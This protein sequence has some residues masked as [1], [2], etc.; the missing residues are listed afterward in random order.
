MKKKERVAN[1]VVQA[2]KLLKDATRILKY[3]GGRLAPAA[4]DECGGW[5]KALA[6]ALDGTRPDTTDRERLESI[7][8]ASERLSAAMKASEKLL[9][10]ATIREYVES[11]GTAVVLALLVR[12]FVFEAFHIPT[13]SMIPTVNIA[14]H[15]FVNKYIYGLR[16]PFTHKDIVGGRMPSRGEVVVFDFPVPGENYGQ[17]FLKRV[18]GLPGDRVRL[19]GNVLEINGRPIEVKPIVHDGDC[20]DANL[21]ACLCARQVERVGDVEYVSQHIAGTR[22]G[23][24]ETCR[25]EPEWPVNNPMSFGSPVD[26]PD[27]PY[28]VVPEGHVLCMGDNRD[29]SSDGRYWGFVPIDNIR[30]RA[31]FFWWPPS[32]MFRKVSQTVPESVPVK[33]VP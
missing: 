15:M 5:L 25:N 16:I 33:V 10:T 28:V 7:R 4:R 24:P 19:S 21:A 23:L 3:R 30:G 22:P 20:G 26:N 18:I 14:D 11:I 31:T 12:A 32:K 29:N 17:A 6:K 9:S 8:Q 27:F 13:G 2:R 1:P